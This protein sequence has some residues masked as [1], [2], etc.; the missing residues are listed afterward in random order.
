M[1]RVQELIR[2]AGS[3]TPPLRLVERAEDVPESDEISIA[4]AACGVCRTD[5]RLVEG[6]LAPRRLPIVP[7]HQVVGRVTAVG[8]AV[9]RWRVGDRVGVAWLA[10]SC[11]AVLTPSPRSWCQESQRIGR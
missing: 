10:G 11:G 5:L 7:G 4:V 3:S 6:D 1:L 9:T 8:E 2:P